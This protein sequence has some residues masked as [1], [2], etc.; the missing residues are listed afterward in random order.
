MQDSG[1]GEVTTG[2]VD[3]VRGTLVDVLVFSGRTHT[4]YSGLN[5]K[6]SRHDLCSVI[7]SDPVHRHR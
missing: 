1:E 3:V 6:P 4:L 2:D 5:T 7:Y